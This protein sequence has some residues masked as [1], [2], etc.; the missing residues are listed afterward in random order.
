[1]AI[2]GPHIASMS[3]SPCAYLLFATPRT[4][5][6]YLCD[7]LTQTGRAGR[8]SEYFGAHIS[9]SLMARWLTPIWSDYVVRLQSESSTANNVFGAKLTWRH[10]QRLVDGLW[11][12]NNCSLDVADVDEL[13]GEAFPG[14]RYMWI[15]RRDKVR[16]AV[17]FAK[18]I[19]TG[20]WSRLRGQSELRSTPH[21]DA[22]Q[23]GRLLIRV[24]QDEE[25]ILGMLRHS[26]RPVMR[27]TY[28]DLVEE[29][30]GVVR[31]VLAFLGE[32]WVGMARLGDPRLERQ[33]DATSE[34]WV[35]RYLRHARGAEETAHGH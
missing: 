2:D 7:A 1:M 29:R 12:S 31:D 13:L 10:L 16:Q 35:A 32:R 24:R 25:R 3:P 26:Q 19:Q 33:A 34:E 21:F 17:S 6:Y 14:L 22:A 8:P 20:N 5:S 15:T 27:L 30:D 18:A 4:G 28:E 23:V 11:L 9:E